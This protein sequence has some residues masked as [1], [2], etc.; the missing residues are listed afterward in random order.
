M[1][2]ADNLARLHE[3]DVMRAQHLPRR[4]DDRLQ[5]RADEGVAM[6]LAA[7]EGARV[8]AKEGKMRREFLAKRHVGGDSSNFH[9]AYWVDSSAKAT[10]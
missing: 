5:G 3:P 10:P 6:R 7:G 2:I 4:G 1:S 8:A 9:R